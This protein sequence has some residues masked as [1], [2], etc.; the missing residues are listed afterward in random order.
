MTLSV[1]RSLPAD[2]QPLAMELFATVIEDL[3]PAIASPVGSKV[4]PRALLNNV[5]SKRA[6]TGET[7][8]IR[9]TA[10]W[11]VTPTNLQF[12]RGGLDT[13]QTT[14]TSHRCGVMI[15]CRLR[16]NSPTTGT[17]WDCGVTFVGG[18]AGP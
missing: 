13:Q 16:V 4:D 2:K 7:I 3:S 8:A 12:D 14:G 1:I 5:R 18:L 15:S 6:A 11:K 9:L 10:S 17:R